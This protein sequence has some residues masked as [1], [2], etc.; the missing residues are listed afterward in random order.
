MD[1][2]M[3]GWSYNFCHGSRLF[4]LLHGVSFLRL[5][6]GSGI[7]KDKFLARI[8]LP[9]FRSRRRFLVSERMV[10]LRNSSPY[11]RVNKKIDRK[12]HDLDKPSEVPRSGEPLHSGAEQPRI[13]TWVL[14][15]GLLARL[16]ARTAHSFACSRLL[17]LLAAYAVLTHSLAR[18]FHSFPRSGES[19]FWFCFTV[20]WAL[21]LCP[22]VKYQRCF[23]SGLY[24]R[25][26]ALLSMVM[27]FF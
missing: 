4:S 13:G 19:W 11:L 10:A 1:G 20:R 6:H 15:T 8:C 14:S 24:N 23:Y 16:F 22:L 7:G 26:N 18:L 17:A 21:A 5:H 3:R 9:A 27:F 25:H 12:K 2:H